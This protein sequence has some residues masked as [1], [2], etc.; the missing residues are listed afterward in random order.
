M[1]INLDVIKELGLD[2]KKL[3]DE[4]NKARKAGNDHKTDA[5]ASA[6]TSLI[7]RLRS[8]VSNGNG[9][10]Q[11]NSGQIIELLEAG[12]ANIESY[13]GNPD[14]DTTDRLI[15]RSQLGDIKIKIGMAKIRETFRWDNLLSQSDLEEFENDLATAAS[16]LRRRK[17]LQS[18]VR[19]VFGIFTIGAGIVTRILG[20]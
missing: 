9:A 17:K 6:A 7:A 18:I 8:A 20:I 15:A 14:L 19:S 11:A 12:R 2:S 16:E 4:I 5:I 13:L 1:P 3:F 10:G